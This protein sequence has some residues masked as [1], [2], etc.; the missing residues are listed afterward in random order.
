MP[1]LHLVF[2][3]GVY[4]S[5]QF[6]MLI[7]MVKLD[8]LPHRCNPNFPQIEHKL[9]IMHTVSNHMSLKSNWCS[10]PKWS[11]VSSFPR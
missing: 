7:L 6:L 8:S 1:L 5:Q 9:R 4:H 11:G 3:N 10:N 2:K